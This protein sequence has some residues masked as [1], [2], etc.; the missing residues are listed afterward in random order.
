M[1]FY[2]LEETED[3]TLVTPIE[4][5]DKEKAREKYKPLDAGIFIVMAEE[6]LDNLAMQRVGG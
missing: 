1:K 4:A 3:D 5:K 6:E 2:I